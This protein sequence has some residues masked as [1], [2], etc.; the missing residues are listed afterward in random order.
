MIVNTQRSTIPGIQRSDRSHFNPMAR[1][2]TPANRLAMKTKRKRP[3]EQNSM[4]RPAPKPDRTP[5]EV[6]LPKESWE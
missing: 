6:I 1:S 3:I 2:G 4:H 5:G